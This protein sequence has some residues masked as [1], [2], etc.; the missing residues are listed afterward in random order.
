M[1]TQEVCLVSEPGAGAHYMYKYDKLPV[2]VRQ[3]LKECNTNICTYCLCQHASN[4]HD[5]RELH[6]LI[7]LFEA[8]DY[9]AITNRGTIQDSRRFYEEERS[10]R[11]YDY[12][13]STFADVNYFERQFRD[14]D[15][16]TRRGIQQ[17]MEFR[18]G[19]YD[20][21]YTRINDEI[22]PPKRFIDEQWLR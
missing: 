9:D 15:Y 18:S 10:R 13:N 5:E 8:G 4:P 12:S 7:N 20:S 19:S 17:G 22:A 11:V 6:Y 2:S 21:T 14:Y 3:R 16:A 1:T